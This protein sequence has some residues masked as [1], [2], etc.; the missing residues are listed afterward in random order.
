MIVQLFVVAALAIWANFDARTGKIGTLWVVCPAAVLAVLDW[1]GFLATYLPAFAL[2][3]GIYVL[4]AKKG[5]GRLKMGFA[6]VMALPFFLMAVL[7]ANPCYMAIAALALAC[8]VSLFRWMPAF[9]VGRK[10]GA[11]N[12]RFVPLL[13][14][15]A[16][17][18]IP[19]LF[20][21]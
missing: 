12:I 9:L 3:A 16:I 8:Q 14:N 11:G 10:D 2:F 4:L 20:I 17:L 15:S 21:G 7:T 13:F 19:G 18:A 6:D 1:T 5:K